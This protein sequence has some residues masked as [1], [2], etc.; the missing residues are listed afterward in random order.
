MKL[1]QKP[2]TTIWLMIY[3]VQFDSKVKLMNSQQN[4][5]Y[6]ETIGDWAG[7]LDQFTIKYPSAGPIP[8]SLQT[9]K[10]PCDKMVLEPVSC[11]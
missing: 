8:S 2:R 6:K 1:C 9:P 7:W 3:E 11:S 10:P 4:P 5:R